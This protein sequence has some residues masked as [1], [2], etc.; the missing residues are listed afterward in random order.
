MAK[1]TPGI[2]KEESNVLTVTPRNF[3]V[4]CLLYS[5]S[6]TKDGG[7]FVLAILLVTLRL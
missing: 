3:W 4:F 5:T 7:G 6:W 2:V 1:K